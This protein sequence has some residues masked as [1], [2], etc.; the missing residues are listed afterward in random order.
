MKRKRT[1]PSS[2][3]AERGGGQPG[4]GVDPS[5]PPQSPSPPAM[6]RSIPIGRPITPK[7]YERLK[8]MAEEDQPPCDDEN[9][10]D[11]RLDE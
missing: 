4:R 1:K 3:K 8:K 10:A 6:P 2:P 11:A 9:D 7:E 5:S